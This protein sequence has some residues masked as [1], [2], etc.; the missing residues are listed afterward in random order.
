MPQGEHAGT[1][2]VR[3]TRRSQAEHRLPGI[4]L[5]APTLPP[6]AIHPGIRACAQA[7][8]HDHGYLLVP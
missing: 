3:T 5:L 4:R 2:L 8:F 6:T 1:W 7:A